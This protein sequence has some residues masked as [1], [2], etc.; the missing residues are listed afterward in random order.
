MNINNHKAFLTSID[1]YA[2][3]YCSILEDNELVSL[4]LNFWNWNKI[5]ASLSL[6]AE[7]D[8]PENLVPFYG[9]WHDLYCLDLETGKIFYLNDDRD[10]ICEWTDSSAFK[11]SLSCKEPADVGTE[12]IV[13]VELDF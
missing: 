12:G 11:E 4:T 1:E 13:S 9:D 8:V 5:T 6:R 7:W 3:G 10:V 2:S